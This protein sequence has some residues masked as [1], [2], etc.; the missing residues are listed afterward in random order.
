MNEGERMSNT[1]SNEKQSRLC[2][3]RDLIP[4]QS[5]CT[6]DKL[7]SLTGLYYFFI[8]SGFLLTA[9]INLSI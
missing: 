8:G 2:A 9:T 3:L 5:R 4:C 6:T 1:T 7:I